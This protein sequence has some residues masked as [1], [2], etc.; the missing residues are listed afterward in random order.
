MDDLLI[1][2]KA[3]SDDTRLKLFTML[4]NSDCCVG[5]LARHL[6]VTE[7]NISQH[8]QI[9]RK[10]GLVVGEKRGYWTHYSVVREKLSD[11]TVTLGAM[12]E[13]GNK[14]PLKCPRAA[15]KAVRAGKD[16]FCGGCCILKDR[17]QARQEV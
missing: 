6:G 12:A 1:C 3:L 17:D 5:A 11:M 16:S 8:L 14:E 4:L 15:G 7:A 10:A 13:T 2:L 9:L